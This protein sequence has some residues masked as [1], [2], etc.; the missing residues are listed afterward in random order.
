MADVGG[1]LFTGHLR[2]FDV[3]VVTGA[4]VEVPA[5]AHFR[6]SPGGAVAVVFACG[7]VDVGEDAESCFVIADA[8]TDADIATGA[9]VCFILLKSDVRNYLLINSIVI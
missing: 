1:D 7:G 6:V 3:Q 5:C 9:G 2:A 8:K 4:D